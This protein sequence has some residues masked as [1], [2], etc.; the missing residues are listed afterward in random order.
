MNPF[1]F[2]LLALTLGAASCATI[3]TESLEAPPKL[4]PMERPAYQQCMSSAK[5]RS[6][7]SRCISAE[8]G[9]QK[10]QLDKLYSRL[11]TK[12]NDQQRGDLARSQAAWEAFMKEETRFEVSFYDAQGGSSDLTV[13][14]NEIKWI[15][16]RRQQLRQHDDF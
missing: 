14:T 13:G 11:S 4:G 12:L 2:G 10:D 5:G 6:E 3:A 7:Q 15:V 1:R 16:Q 8:K 9:W